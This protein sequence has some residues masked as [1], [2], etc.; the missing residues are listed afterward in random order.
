M[1]R[2][3][4][5]TPFSISQSMRERSRAD[6]DPKRE[7]RR[8]TKCL[9]PET[10]EPI[11]FDQHG[12]CNTCR[13]AV[14]RNEVIDWSERE[15]EFR[16]IVESY[17]GKYDYDAIVP[18]S[19]GKDSAWT[20]YVL[21]TQ[22]KLKVLLTTFDSNF[23]RPIHLGNVDK[24]VR[25]LG[26]DHVVFKAS[27]EIVR[28]TMIEMLKRKGDFCWFCHTGVVAFPFKM[29]LKYRVPLLIWGEPG[30]EYS[31]G[32]YGYEVKN[33]ADERWFNRQINLSVNSSDMLGYL[34]GIDPRDVEPFRFPDKSLLDELGVRSIH[35]GD[36]KK[37]DAPTQ[38]EILNR[39]LGWEPA[40]VELLHPRYNYEKVECFLQGTRDYLRYI[41]RGQGRTLQRANLEIRNGT[42]TRDEAEK[43]IQYDGQ[44][45]QSLDVVL[46]YLGISEDEFNAIGE[47]HAIYPY[48]HDWSATRR[49]QMK[50]PDQGD[51][52]RRLGDS[53]PSKSDESTIATQGTKR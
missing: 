34:P 43:M 36:Y 13:S 6:F 50:V 29:A 37:W 27:E 2:R 44:R 21:V 9:M 24:V 18:F 32:Y 15:K 1:T 8:C 39:E 52:E 35:L 12:V 31:G 23:R 14:Y 46:K 20:A 38:F 41:K 22:Y 17:R 11:D 47:S 25:K 53:N 10:Q 51:W 19:G 7:L 33:P 4:E 30:S 3:L 16:D 49:A 40:D 42:L 5:P 48:V 45:P 26:C 28:K